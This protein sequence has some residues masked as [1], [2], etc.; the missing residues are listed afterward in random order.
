MTH[1]RT[2]LPLVTS[3]AALCL[4]L[5]V[6]GAPGYAQTGA[7]ARAGK[8][9]GA[10]ASPTPTA[11]PL[12]GKKAAGKRS[13]GKKVRRSKKKPVSAAKGPKKQPVSA[14]ERPVCAPEVLTWLRGQLAAAQKSG[15]PSELASLLLSGIL[16]NAFTQALH[17]HYALAGLGKALQKGAMDRQAVQM[18]AQDMARNLRQG[19]RTFA[20]LAGHKAL[21]QLTAVF[22]SLAALSVSGSATATELATWAATKDGSVLGFDQALE[23][24]R[25]GVEAFARQVRGGVER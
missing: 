5:C 1:N 23:H 21:G 9:G 17:S 15:K 3:C 2:T 14:G 24:Y 6:G 20:A 18:M 13:A 25:I 10:A 19:Q 12:Q 22:S 11:T 4:A 16:E 7:A 8:A